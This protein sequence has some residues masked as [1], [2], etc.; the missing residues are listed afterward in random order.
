MARFLRSRLHPGPGG[1]VRRE[2]LNALLRDLPSQ[3]FAQPFLLGHPSFQ[4]FV[5][6]VPAAPKA[7]GE[8]QQ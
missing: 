3:V 6:T 4:G 1:P 5:E 2:A 8:I 7:L